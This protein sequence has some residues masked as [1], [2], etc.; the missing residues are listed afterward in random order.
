MNEIVNKFLLV[1]EKFVKKTALTT[2][3]EN[4]IPDVSNWVKK[5]IMTLKL[6]KLKIN[7]IIIITIN[8]LLLQNLIL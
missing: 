4:E 3:F 8:L 1:G 6:R 7:L 5:H 2:V